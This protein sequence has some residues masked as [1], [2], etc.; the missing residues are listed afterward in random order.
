MAVAHFDRMVVACHEEHS[1]RTVRCLKLRA[2][3]VGKPFLA[4]GIEVVAGLV[5]QE[6]GGFCA[7]GHGEQQ[8]LALAT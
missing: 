4:F 3:H 2:Q 8:A 5:Q 7:D 1:G 6:K